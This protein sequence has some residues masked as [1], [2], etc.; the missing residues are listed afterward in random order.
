MF[1]ALVARVGKDQL[2]GFG[3]LIA[4]QLIP[5]MQAAEACGIKAPTLILL[6]H[7]FAALA[8]FLATGNGAFTAAINSDG[9]VEQPTPAAPEA[10]VQAVVQLGHLTFKGCMVCSE[11]RAMAAMKA[12][13]ES[14]AAAAT[15]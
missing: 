9:E 12:M 6:D 15:N 13:A 4:G 5:R 8:Y 7:E 3:R 2:K 11:G 14:Q 10:F 1:D